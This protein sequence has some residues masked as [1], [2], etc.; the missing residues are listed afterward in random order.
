VDFGSIAG[1]GRRSPGFVGGAKNKGLREGGG[2]R[3]SGL[4]GGVGGRGMGR[5]AG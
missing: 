1:G 5:A 3:S 4:D 2:A